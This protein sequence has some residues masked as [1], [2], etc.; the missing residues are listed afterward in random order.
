MGGMY[1]RWLAARDPIS[2][3]LVSAAARGA[4]GRG[5]V[6]ERRGAGQRGGRRARVNAVR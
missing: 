1:V 2:Q 4:A 5:E 6:R 3:L